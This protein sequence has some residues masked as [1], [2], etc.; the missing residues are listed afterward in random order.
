MFVC[1]NQNHIL[2]KREKQINFTLLCGDLLKDDNPA[3]LL[4]SLHLLLH[5]SQ[6][7]FFFV[8]KKKGGRVEHKLFMKNKEPPYSQKVPRE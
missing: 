1:M 4:S 8:T 7:F 3:G 6:P 2:Q 5:K